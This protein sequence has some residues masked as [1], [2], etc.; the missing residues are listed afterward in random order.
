MKILSR[1]YLSTY[2]WN[3]I[4][5]SKTINQPVESIPASAVTE[6]FYA[7]PLIILIV[8]QNLIELEF[9]YPIR[10]DVSLFQVKLEREM[11]HFPK[12]YFITKVL[13]NSQSWK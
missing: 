1:I 9:I 11:N 4:H 12:I 2:F 13:S 5:A 8:R 3:W 10:N 7:I 6:K